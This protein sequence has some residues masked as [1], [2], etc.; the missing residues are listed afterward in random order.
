MRGDDRA[1][2]D[3]LTKLAASPSS[4]VLAALEHGALRMSELTEN[5]ARLDEETLTAAL[6]D[7]DAAALVARRV[8]PGPPLR[9]LY[10]LTERGAQLAPALG[11]LTKWIASEGSPS[12]R[13]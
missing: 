11:I 8:D 13:G 7:L 12:G 3:L 2:S 5:D 9:V 4:L 10:Q 6:R 1:F